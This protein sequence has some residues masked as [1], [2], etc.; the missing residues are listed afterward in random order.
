[1]FNYKEKRILIV[2][3]FFLVFLF[4]T[5]QAAANPYVDVPTNHWSYDA[6][7]KQASDKVT[8]DNHD[9]GFSPD[10]TMTRVESAAL[11]AKLNG[12]GNSIENRYS[13]GQINNNLN[14]IKDT[15]KDT[16]RPSSIAATPTK[17]SDSDILV[18]ALLASNEVRELPSG[19]G[20]FWGGGAGNVKIIIDGVPDTPIPTPTITQA[21][22][23]I[24]PFTQDKLYQH[25]LDD[26]TKQSGGQ[27]TGGPNCYENSGDMSGSTVAQPI[28]DAPPRHGW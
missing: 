13:Q 1:M 14:Q 19:T 3:A 24:A 15:G 6:P 22:L 16:D 25:L 8:E 4:P 12:I 26:L 5:A 17:T 2:L 20:G 27:C 21:P 23:T 11:I 7:N 28:T 10:L 9:P 18:A